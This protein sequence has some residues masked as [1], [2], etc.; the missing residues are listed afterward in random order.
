M[1]NESFQIWSGEVRAVAERLF[2]DFSDSID[3]CEGV[4]DE[5]DCFLAGFAAGIHHAD[6]DER[7]PE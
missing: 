7:A 2:A 6:P 5:R 4:A 3:A 1:S